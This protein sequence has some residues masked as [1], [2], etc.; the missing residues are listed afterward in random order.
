MVEALEKP[1]PG[2]CGEEK[3]AARQAAASNLRSVGVD[4]A[5]RVMGILPKGLAGLA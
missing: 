5:G 1:A 3:G 4:G 2:E